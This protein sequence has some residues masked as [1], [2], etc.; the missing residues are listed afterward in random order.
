MH[1]TPQQVAQFERD[2]YLVFLGL[3]SRAE[4]A[5]L[6]AETERLSRIDADTVVRERTGGVRSIFR[7]HEDDGAT[8]SAAFWGAE[9]PSLGRGPQAII[10]GIAIHGWSAGNRRFAGQGSWKCCGG[11]RSLA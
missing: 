10:Y 7:V 5:V 1:L 8:R 6:R 4:V 11:H 3:F 9:P 2:G